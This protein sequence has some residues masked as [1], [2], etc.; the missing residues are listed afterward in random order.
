MLSDSRSDCHWPGHAAHA[1]LEARRHRTGQVRHQ[2]RGRIKV[3]ATA[4][5][6]NHCRLRGLP[7]SCWDV[8]V[9]NA[10]PRHHLGSRGRQHP[11]GDLESAVVLCRQEWRLR[12]RGE[13]G[14]AIGHVH[15]HVRSG[16]SQSLGGKLLQENPNLCTCPLGRMGQ[17]PQCSSVSLCPSPLGRDTPISLS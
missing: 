17:G 9:L 2:A 10:R 5:Q 8:R 3:L 1:S 11:V 15:P 7:S 16:T 4:Q 6:E 12:P 14:E 13:T